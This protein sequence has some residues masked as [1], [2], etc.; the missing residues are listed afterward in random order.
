[1]RAVQCVGVYTYHAL[2]SDGLT[3]KLPEYT[4]VC[5]FRLYTILYQ[6]QDL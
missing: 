1:M 5:W 3:V 2:T 6:I 4:T